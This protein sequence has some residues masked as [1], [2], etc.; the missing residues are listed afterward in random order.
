MR[1][2]ENFINME[3]AEAVAKEIEETC[4]ALAEQAATS[5]PLEEP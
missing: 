4:K 3:I 1:T 2:A 5:L